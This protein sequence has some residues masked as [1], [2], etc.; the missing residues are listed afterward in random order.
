MGFLWEYIYYRI[1]EISTLSDWDYVCI[2]GNYNNAG[3]VDEEQKLRDRGYSEQQVKY[4]MKGKGASSFKSL[5]VVFHIDNKL[6]YPYFG[7]IYTLYNQ[8]KQGVLPFPGSMSE[9]PAKIIEIFDVLQQLELEQEEKTRKKLEKE[10]KRGK[11]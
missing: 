9:Q 11:N 5:D 4:A 7:Y 10:S 1:F 8:Y 6:K 2:V 3:H